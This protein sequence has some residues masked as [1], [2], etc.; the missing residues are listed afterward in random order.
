MAKCYKKGQPVTTH[1]VERFDLGD[2]YVMVRELTSKDFLELE[3]KYPA[4]NEAKVFDVVCDLLSRCIVD[5]D[6]SP[7]FTDGDDLQANFPVGL[8]TIWALRDKVDAMSAPV[9]KGDN[10]N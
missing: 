5:D 4:G 6:G 10:P 1:K 7:L 2:D 8:S 3:A 9:A